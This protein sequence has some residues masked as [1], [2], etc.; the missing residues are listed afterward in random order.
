MIVEAQKTKSLKIVYGEQLD[1][2][3]QLAAARELVT[4]LSNNIV[5]M[6][7]LNSDRLLAISTFV[8]EIVHDLPNYSFIFIVTGFQACQPSEYDQNVESTG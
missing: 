5:E 8:M 6:Y 1:T 2:V 3:C 4:M 7:V